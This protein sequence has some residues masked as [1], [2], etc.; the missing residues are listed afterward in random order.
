MKKTL[1]KIT[2]IALAAATI[3]AAAVFTACSNSSG[4]VPYVPTSG[5]SQSGTGSGT[6]TQ[7]GGENGQG[8]NNGGNSGGQ[9]NFTLE[10]YYYYE[11]TV[12]DTAQIEDIIGLPINY[13]SVEQKPHEVESGEG[14]VYASGSNITGEAAGTA[15]IK[16]VINKDS[17]FNPQTYKYD[18]TYE[19]RLVVTVT[20]SSQGG[21]S[22]SQGGSQDTATSEGL[23]SFLTGDWTCS[24]TCNGT[25]YSGT[26][27]LNANG[28]GHIKITLGSST[29]HD[30][31]FSW[32][33][34][35][36]ASSGKTWKTLV[37]SGAGSSQGAI[38]GNH[39][40]TTSA[41][42]FVMSGNFGFGMPS[43]TSWTRQ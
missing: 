22:G 3:F 36:S 37:I 14:V 18:T 5:G 33:A 4:G 6:G 35:A 11:M 2:T 15:I 1:S 17:S 40:L 19:T 9:Q 16:V 7:T 27:S 43:Q 26:L 41:S 29:A 13:L 25:R 8:E 42:G 21:G 32:T 34:S 28:S 38:D 39:S 10:P 23:K 24:G 31:D 12:Y 20:E 30:T